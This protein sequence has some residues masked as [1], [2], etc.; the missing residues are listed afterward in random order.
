[1]LLKKCSIN[2]PGKLYIVSTPIG[3]LSDISKRA[4]ATLELVDLVAC[5][6]TRITK[7]ILT[8]YKICTKMITYNNINENRISNKILNYL[9][10]GK[11][12]ALV[13][14]A[15]T[16][17]ISDPGYRIVNQCHKEKIEVVSVPGACSVISSLSISGLPTDSFYFEGFLPRKKGRKTKLEFLK[18]LETTIIIFESP[19]RI[20]KTLDDIYE[21]MG[22]RIVSVTKELTKFHEEVL[23]DKLENLIHHFSAKSSIKGEYIIL[24]SKEGYQIK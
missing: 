12:V 14:D 23:L 16:P 10:E 20:I 22:N 2:L 8:H 7:K 1:M 19:K 24:I 9:N 6:D 4:L 11:E 5:E 13:S 18:D 3:N 21:Y 17:C 15:G